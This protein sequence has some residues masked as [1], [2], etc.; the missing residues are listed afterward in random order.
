MSEQNSEA[1]SISHAS[2]DAADLSAEPWTLR[3]RR[4]MF[5]GTFLGMAEV[6][7][8]GL[9]IA[10]GAR[11]PRTL[12]GC[13]M[14]FAAR[15]AARANKEYLAAQRLVSA[16]AAARTEGTRQHVSKSTDA[17]VDAGNA[18]ALD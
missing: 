4:I 12:Y 2:D 3:H 6:L 11:N 16:L 1:K 14:F 17:D 5:R 13:A 9:Y 7:A 8:D 15:R 18:S 10:A